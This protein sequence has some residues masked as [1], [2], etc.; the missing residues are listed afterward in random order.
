VCTS[1]LAFFFISRGRWG[2]GVHHIIGK[3][4]LA[5]NFVWLFFA[6]HLAAAFSL[7]FLLSLGEGAVLVFV[8]CPTYV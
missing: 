6:S 7:F 4:G 1:F 5:S 3:D 2:S 8:V